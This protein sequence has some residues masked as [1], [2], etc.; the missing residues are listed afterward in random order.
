MSKVSYNIFLRAYTQ[1]Y[2]RVTNYFLNYKAK[3]SVNAARNK[4]VS[5]LEL[6]DVESL[7][8]LFNQNFSK[9]DKKAY[10]I[11]NRSSRTIKLFFEYDQLNTKRYK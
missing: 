8:F 11:L 1:N 6:R 5:D 7:T 4:Y 3:N 2:Q 10:T 9:H